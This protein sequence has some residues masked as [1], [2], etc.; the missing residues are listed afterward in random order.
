M[1]ETFPMPAILNSGSDPKSPRK[2]VRF[3]YWPMNIEEEIGPITIARLRWKL[4]IANQKFIH[5]RTFFRLPPCQGRGKSFLTNQ[6]Q[7]GCALLL[8]SGPF[9]CQSLSHGEAPRKLPQQKLVCPAWCL[10]TRTHRRQHPSGDSTTTLRTGRLFYWTPQQNTSEK[11]LHGV[12][13]SAA[14][15]LCG[16]FHKSQEKRAAETGE[17]PHELAF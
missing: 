3:T 7:P 2:L 16:P 12:S 15:S 1:N 6:P 13:R 10:F 9:N 17:E 4:V 8:R 14:L 5:S 11:T